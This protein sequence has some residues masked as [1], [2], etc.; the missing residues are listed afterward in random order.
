MILYHYNINKTNYLYQFL[1]NLILHENILICSL[2]TRIIHNLILTIV[3]ISLN[4]K[5]L[6]D[7]TLSYFP[8]FSGLFNYL[9]LYL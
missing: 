5:K 9:F 4:V 7:S 1:Y 2:K 3:H 6:L 8:L